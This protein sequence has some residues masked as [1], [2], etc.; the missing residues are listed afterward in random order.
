MRSMPVA[1]PMT[2]EEFLAL[3]D[4]DDLRSGVV[5]DLHYELLSWAR[6][7][8]ERGTVWLDLGIRLDERNVYQPD[9]LWYP[10]GTGPDVYS[11]PPSPLPQ[12]AIEV[13]SPSTWRYDIGAKKS[14]YERHG[15]QEL[16][17][18]DTAARAV[19]V[20]TRSTPDAPSFD[21]ARELQGADAL[22]SPRLQGFELPLGD[23]FP[24]PA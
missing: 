12:L 3:P 22:S 19:L 6:A 5:G 7:G 17:L 10:E 16:W 4:A 11:N 18:I 1:E 21:L 23:L 2:A 20:F 15:L 14:A 13:R 9:L 8:M 24:P